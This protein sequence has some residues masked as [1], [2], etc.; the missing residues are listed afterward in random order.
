MNACQKIWDSANNEL[1]YG[2]PRDVDLSS[3]DTTL[4]DKS[5]SKIILCWIKGSSRRWKPFIQN[6]VE[7]IQQKYSDGLRPSGRKDIL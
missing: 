1:A 3:S 7:I 2:V 5:Y 6:R 4:T